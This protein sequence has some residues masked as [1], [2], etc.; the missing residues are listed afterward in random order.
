MPIPAAQLV[1]VNPSVISGGGNA[2]TLNGVILTPS[3]AVPMRAVQPFASAEAVSTFFGPLSDEAALANVYFAGRDNATVLPSNLFFS[4]YALVDAAAWLR[5]GSIAG[6][7][8]AQLQA[9]TGVLT[10]TINGTAATSAAINL[11][12]ATSF[13][14]A[15]TIIQNAFTSPTFGVTYDSVRGAFLFTST[16]TGATASITVATGSLSTGLKLTT[17]TG[18]ITSQGAVASTPAVVMDAVVAVTQNFAAFMTIFEPSTADKLNFAIWNA[19]KN[20]RYVYVAFDTD[21]TATQAG[22]TTAFGPQVKL[23]GYEGVVPVYQSNLHAAFVLGMI[24][25]L[26]FART[27]G[28]IT[29]AYKSLAG[30]LPSVTTESTAQILEANGYNFYGQYSTANQGFTFFYPGLVSGKY[31]FLDEYVNEIYLNS[32]IQ[33]ALL[34]LLTGTTSIPYNSQGYALIDAAVNDP[35]IEAL[36]FGSIRPNVPLSS[37]QA[38]TVN[39][40]AGAQIANT[41]QSRGWYLQIKPAT[42]QVRASR[43]SPP[44]TL[45]YMDGGSV[46]K[47]VLASILIQ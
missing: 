40:I 31:L 34:T 39:N 45:F 38:A 41:L 8:L 17:A 21:V 47:I 25:S 44:M 37:Q 18:A 33:L 23:A 6:A 12:A 43:G 46:H 9:L 36:N 2:L 14:N 13:S 27:N 10:L 4:R 28:R 32:Q 24:A 11:S 5:G 26:D 1:Q 29:F 7:T 42:A 20:K 16:L 15:A 35:I 3:S 30:L 19:S 22:N